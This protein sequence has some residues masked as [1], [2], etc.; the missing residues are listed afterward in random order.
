VARLLA[1]VAPTAAFLL[2]NGAWGVL[3]GMLVSSAA[4]VSVVLV[5]L[6]RGQG[7]GWLSLAVL[8]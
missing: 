8:A 7:V 2:A 3:A 6:R 4:A 5:R 1:S